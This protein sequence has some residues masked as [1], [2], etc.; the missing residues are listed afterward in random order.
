MNT[1][2]FGLRI[3]IPIKER[4]PICRNLE[5]WRRRANFDFSIDIVD[6]EFCELQRDLVQDLGCVNVILYKHA[7]F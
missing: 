7:T 2:K 4:C 6:I 1:E 3:K 5:M